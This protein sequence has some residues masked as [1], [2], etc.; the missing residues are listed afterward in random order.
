M[1]IPVR[2]G[3]FL[4]YK[5]GYGA[6]WN[7]T[8]LVAD[9]EDFA[10][11]GSTA[12]VAVRETMDVRWEHHHH[13]V[14]FPVREA[15]DAHITPMKVAEE[16][17][18]MKHFTTIDA[19]DAGTRMDSDTVEIPRQVAWDEAVA[20]PPA[21]VEEQEQVTVQDADVIVAPMAPQPVR[22]H[23]TIERQIKWGATEG[24]KGCH[25]HAG[26]GGHDPHCIARF[27]ELAEKERAEK[28]ARPVRPRGRP[29][30]QP[31]E[32]V[33]AAEEEPAAAMAAEEPGLAPAITR[34]IEDGG[35]PADPQA[36]IEDLVADARSL[37]LRSA[38][39]QQHQK[40]FKLQTRDASPIRRLIVEYCCD[41]DSP[42][43]DV[44][45]IPQGTAVLRLTK[46]HDMTKQSSVRNALGI[47]ERSVARGIEVLLWSAIPCTGG[48]TLSYINGSSPGGAEKLQE[49]WKLWA[50]L[51]HNFETL[52][53]RTNKLGG[54][55]AIEW[56]R[57]CRY[58]QEP[59]V[60]RLMYNL[61]L[62]D[63]DFDGCQLGMHSAEG[64]PI[65]KPWRVATND[66]EV[67]KALAGRLCPGVHRHHKWG[68]KMSAG[69]ASYPR[70]MCQAIQ[71]MGQEYRKGG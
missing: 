7:K 11:D 10:G 47:I 18:C 6:K 1:D 23:V 44:K 48:S 45:T 43:A 30:N 66:I 62:A 68:G 52:A 22:T 9:C 13:G 37:Q 64:L 33:R 16:L 61:D 32:P 15:K 46:E 8:Y 21:A 31:A 71:C 55:I 36:N 69:T 35:D 59:C 70:S 19:Q 29:R 4:G 2:W 40:L 63:A 67:H 26:P 17:R 60:R 53:Y 41:S 28:A 27:R 34:P 54:R 57:G 25:N 14:R 5:L 24:C 58:W 3:I 39:E 49:H 50:R 38:Q 20:E 42:I 51:W 65:K 12:R 56:P